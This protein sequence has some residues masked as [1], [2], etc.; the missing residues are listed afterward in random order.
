MFFACP[1]C[2]QDMGTKEAFDDH[3]A[4]A[5]EQIC[6]FLEVPSSANPEDGITSRIEDI[7]IGRKA[8]SKIDSW[9][10]LWRLLFPI[11]AQVKIPDS[12][13]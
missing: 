12:G 11:D 8:G 3:L 2:K 5:N 10:N 9:E 7:L 13:T 1:R 4:V 6:N